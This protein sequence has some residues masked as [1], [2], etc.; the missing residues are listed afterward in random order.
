MLAEQATGVGGGDDSHELL[1]LGHQGTADVVGGHVVKH[2]VERL[3]SLDDIRF[4]FE[5]VI[6][7]QLFLWRKPQVRVQRSLRSRSVRMPTS[8]PWS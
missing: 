6:D 4:R 5:D 2:G 8:L 3:K 7:E 1:V